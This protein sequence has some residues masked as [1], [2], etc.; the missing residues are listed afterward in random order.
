MTESL[1]AT[2]RPSVSR[3]RTNGYYRVERKQKSDS[4]SKDIRRHGTPESSDDER[5]DRNGKDSSDEEEENCPQDVCT[6]LTDSCVWTDSTPK[7][8]KIDAE[9]RSIAHSSSSRRRKKRQRESI[10]MAVFGPNP[11]PKPSHDRPAS[12]RRYHTTI[13]LSTES[14]ISAHKKE[15]KPSPKTPRRNSG[16]LLTLFSAPSPPSKPPSRKITCITCRDDEIP[17]LKSSKLSCGHRMCHACIK[18]VFVLSTQDPQLM[19]PKCCT[20]EMIPLERVQHLFSEAFKKRWNKKFDEYSTAN[21]LYCPSKGCGEWIDPKHIKLDRVV[22]R[23]FGVCGKCKTKVCKKCGLRWHGARDCDNDDE[24][25]K[26][27]DMGK[28]QGWQRCYSCRAMV[29]LSEGCNHMKC[30]CGV[31]FCYVCGEKWKTC[32]CPWFNVPPEGQAPLPWEDFFRVDIRRFRIPGGDELPPPPPP[33][34]FRDRRDMPLDPLN[35]P[36]IFRPP[37]MPRPPDMPRPPAPPMRPTRRERERRQERNRQAPDERLTQEAQDEALARRLQEQ[38]IDT[39]LGIGDLNLEPSPA[40]DRAARRERRRRAA[41]LRDDGEDNWRD[42]L[43]P[44]EVGEG[45][46]EGA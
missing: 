31:E 4:R 13:P 23:R 5:W 34:V 21:R 44:I 22:G 35:L 7:Q 28:E 17:V 9:T 3:R 8:S 2:T 46:V 20:E 42:R 39:G 33:P 25:K 45:A 27:I 1:I 26:V 16:G 12:V 43:R 6:P 40:H 11:K 37:N 18:R 32:D 24:T 30:R 36:D 38:E 15:D 29:Q 10:L 41:A 14:T 19:P